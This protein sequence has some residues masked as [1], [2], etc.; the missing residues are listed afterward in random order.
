[1]RISL[2][3]INVKGNVKNSEKVNVEYCDKGNVNN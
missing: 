3:N 1:M 2:R